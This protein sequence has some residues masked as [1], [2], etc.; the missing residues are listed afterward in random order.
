[1]HAD[2]SVRRQEPNVSPSAV[3][4]VLFV[5]YCSDDSLMFGRTASKEGRICETVGVDFEVEIVTSLSQIWC[6]LN[7]FGY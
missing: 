2:D 6:R 4:C 5:S 3:Q 7:W 1:M